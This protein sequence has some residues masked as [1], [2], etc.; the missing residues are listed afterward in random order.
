MDD[1]ESS[2]AIAAYKLQYAPPPPPPPT[3]RDEATLPS[4]SVHSTCMDS[5]HV[6]YSNATS[7]FMK[8]AT[9]VQ[10]CCEMRW[11]QPSQDSWLGGAELRLMQT[12]KAPQQQRSIRC[13]NTGELNQLL[14]SLPLYSAISTLILL[15]IST[16]RLRAG[17][18][19][20]SKVQRLLVY[21]QKG[22]HS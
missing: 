13:I 2:I 20:R 19:S 5:M 21:L 10:V 9:Y 4:P 16:F 14:L 22:L 7:T 15:L 1:D 17:L 11:L 12:T 6:M 8:H 18:C 3:F